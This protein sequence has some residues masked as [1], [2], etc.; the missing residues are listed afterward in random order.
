MLSRS[1]PAG[2]VGGPLFQ[3]LPPKSVDTSNLNQECRKPVPQFQQ[4]F[5]L[6]TPG[7]P[8]YLLGSRDRC[9]HRK[10]YRRTPGSHLAAFCPILSSLLIT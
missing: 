3:T 5:L 4:A 9:K 7:H 1:P 8:Q 2:W 6:P 10:V